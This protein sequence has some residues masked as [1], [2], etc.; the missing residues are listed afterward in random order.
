MIL[1]S[2]TLAVGQSGSFDFFQSRIGLTQAESLRL[3]S[4]FDYRRQAQLILLDGHARPGRRQGAAT[5]GSA[6]PMIRRYVARTDGQAF[7]LF[8]S[9]DMM[10]RVAAEL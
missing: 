8:T 2:A 4:P 10:R 9:Y 3:G 7:V 6:W 1:T 5:N